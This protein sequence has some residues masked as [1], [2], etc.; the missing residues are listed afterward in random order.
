MS[1]YYFSLQKQTKK[2]ILT[3]QV[4]GPCIHVYSTQHIFAKGQWFQSCTFEQI[5]GKV[6]MILL[7]IK[8]KLQ[9]Q[10]SEF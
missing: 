4:N 8:K 6:E 9:T 5:T 2:N 3:N 1:Y 10:A 7:N